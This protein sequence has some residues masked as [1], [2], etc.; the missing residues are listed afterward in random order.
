MSQPV[1]CSPPD[2][3]NPY[4]TNT[5]PQNMTCKG[6]IT[7]ETCDIQKYLHSILL[8][9]NVT[10]HLAS[11]TVLS[12]TE[13]GQNLQKCYKIPTIP[14]IQNIYKH[15]TGTHLNAKCLM[16]LIINIHF[17]I[18]ELK[19]I[20]S[21]S[22]KDNKSLILLNS[23]FC[24]TIKINNNPFVVL[25]LIVQ[26][27]LSHDFSKISEESHITFSD[28]L[29]RPAIIRA[30]LIARGPQTPVVQPLWSPD[31]IADAQTTHQTNTRFS[32]TKSTPGVNQFWSFHYSDERK[33]EWLNETW[34]VFLQLINLITQ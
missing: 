10:F 23:L 15:I 24:T 27:Y 33:H 12:N 2:L 25:C 20:L 34:I 13:A 30:R 31:S 22:Q 5:K 28:V 7:V 4:K 6:K 1:C 19:Y 32:K 11:R 3:K 9:K 17:N 26:N 29:I 21:L 8:D 18:W 14:N 16:V